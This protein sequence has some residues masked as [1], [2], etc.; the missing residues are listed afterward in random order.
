[1]KARDLRAKSDEELAKEL[2][3]LSR[4]GFNLRM[5]QGTGQLA[6]PSQFRAVRRDIARVKTIINE[7]RRTK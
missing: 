3:E 6:R 7:R 4:E 2:E 5:Q 1:M